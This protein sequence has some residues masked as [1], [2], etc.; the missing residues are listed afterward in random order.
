M[1]AL[2]APFYVQNRQHPG[3]MPRVENLVDIWEYYEQV[4]TLRAGLLGGRAP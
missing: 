2:D 1:D 3:K 4:P